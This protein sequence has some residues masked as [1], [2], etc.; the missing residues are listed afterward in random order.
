MSNHNSYS[1]AFFIILFFFSTVIPVESQSRQNKKNHNES[2]LKQNRSDVA[3][4]NQISPT[5]I[6]G[7]DNRKDLFEVQNPKMI[8]FAQSTVALIENQKIRHIDES[9]IELKSRKFGE[10]YSLCEGEPF[11]EQ[12]TVAFCSGFFIGK[13]LIITA[14]H[15]IR[16][17][18]SCKNTKFVFDFALNSSSDSPESVK[19]DQVYNCSQ[20][21]HSEVNASGADFAIVQ[22]DREVL[23]RTS[24]SLRTSG[25][26]GINENITVIGHPSGLPTKVA[27]GATVRSRANQHFVTNL[28]TYGGNSGSA[29]IND[30]TG[31]VEGI[32]VRGATDF[33]YRNGCRASNVCAENGCRGEDVSNISEVLKHL[34]TSYFSHH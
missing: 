23:N 14:G 5:V 7:E 11:R 1:T 20:L 13:D 15:C 16:N 26:I 22:L 10:A 8:S 28:D 30:N 29:V 3:N 17:L 25:Q 18:Q 21:I 27:D 4:Q 2:L 19:A 32:L 33:V 31:D 6:Y 9:T 24:L 12:P 34:P